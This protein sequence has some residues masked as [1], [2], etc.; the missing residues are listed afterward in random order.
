MQNLAVSHFSI[1]QPLQQMSSV[2]WHLRAVLHC[3]RSRSTECITGW[4]QNFGRMGSAK[5][6][7]LGHVDSITVL[8]TLE[9][10]NEELCISGSV[11]GANT[12]SQLT[13]V[14]PTNCTASLLHLLQVEY[15]GLAISFVPPPPPLPHFWSFLISVV[16]CCTVVGCL[17]VLCCRSCCPVVRSAIVKRFEPKRDGAL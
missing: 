5:H 4:G 17:R 16:G 12:F 11:V 6:D 14:L 7:R 13:L 10:A 8:H 2:S 3:M 1:V 9:V 15:P